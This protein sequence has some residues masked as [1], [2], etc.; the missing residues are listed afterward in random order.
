MKKDNS[1]IEVLKNYN[2]EQGK[3]EKNNS[4]NDT[5][6]TGQFRKG[7][8]RKRTMPKIQHLKKGQFRK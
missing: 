1:K 3:P 6:E 4:E 8:F 7:K 2:S 5:S